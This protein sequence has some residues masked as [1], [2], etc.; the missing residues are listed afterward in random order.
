MAEGLGTTNTVTN[1]S[2]KAIVVEHLDPEL[3]EWSTLEYAAIADEC[4]KA[5]VLFFVSSIPKDFRL[6]DQLKKHPAVRV[7][8][9]NAEDI[10]AEAKNN[11]CLLD[12]SA[13]EKLRPQDGDKFN[14]FLFGGI[15]GRLDLKKVRLRRA[16]PNVI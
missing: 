7:E 13:D 14:I 12:P 11:I 8:S 2:P 5:G 6:P 16:C 1:A 15:L 9:K 10:F 3:E 4:N